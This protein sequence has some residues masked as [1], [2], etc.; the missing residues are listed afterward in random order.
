MAALLAAGPAAA[1]SHRTAALAWALVPPAGG[2]M[3]HVVLPGVHGRAAPAGVVVHRS[4]TLGPDD[5]AERG[6]LTL[7]GPERTIEDV[8]LGRAGARELRRMVEQAEAHGLLRRPLDTTRRPRL[9]AALDAGPLITRSELEERFLA[10]VHA[11]ALPR[12]RVNALVGAY[13]VDFLWPQHRLVAETDGFAHHRGRDAFERD[14][15]RDRDLAV[16]GLRVVR[17]THADVV[18]DGAQVAAALRALLAA[19]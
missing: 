2:G 16:A 1:L 17:F 6:A 5:L 9:R 11:H 7:T 13:T 15:R 3:V 18:R 4:R 10:L 12:P 8:A 14:R 19:A